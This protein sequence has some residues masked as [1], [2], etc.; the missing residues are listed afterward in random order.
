MPRC[1]SAPKGATKPALGTVKLEADT[2]VAVTERL[3]N[4]KDAKVT[5]SNFP[6]LPNDQLKEVVAEIVKLVPQGALVIGLDRVLARLDKSQ[7]IPRNVADVKADPPVIFYSTTTAVLMNLDGDPIWSPIKDNDLK[8]A[9]NTNWDL[10]Q[11]TTTS[12]YYLRY[13]KSWFTASDVKGPWKP[14]TKLPDSFKTLPDDDGNWKEVKAAVPGTGLAVG[15]SA[16]GVRQHDS[17][18]AHP[19]SGCAELPADRRNAPALGEQLGRRRLQ[20]RQSRTCLLPRVGPLVHRARFHRVR[21][22][23]RRRTLPAD[24]KKI[25]LSHPRSNVLASVPGTD[26][27]AEAVLLAQVPQTATRG[28]EDGEGA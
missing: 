11:H 2:E 14:T 15:A 22:R 21:G 28:Q 24:F 6:G 17:V 8:F 9:V 3:V 23:S 10:F 16:Q 27:A 1:R 20:A 4:F 12:T 13:N 25:P 19:A 7:I 18:R 26:Q 5:E